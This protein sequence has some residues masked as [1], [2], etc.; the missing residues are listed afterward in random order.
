[1]PFFYMIALLRRTRSNGHRSLI[2]LCIAY[3]V[4]SLGIEYRGKIIVIVV[5]AAAAVIVF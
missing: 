4:H 5:A 2:F 3:F 1:M